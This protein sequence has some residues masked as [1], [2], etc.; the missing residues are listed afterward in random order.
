MQPC[1]EQARRAKQIGRSRNALVSAISEAPASPAPRRYEE[2]SDEAISFGQRP[3]RP[4][5]RMTEVA[6]SHRASLAVLAMTWDY[7][8]AFLSR[9]FL[10]IGEATGNPAKK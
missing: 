6:S 5:A 10:P 1:A 4:C 2:R 7:A 3:D 9:F 8:F